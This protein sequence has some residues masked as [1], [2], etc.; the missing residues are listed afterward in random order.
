MMFL[1]IV[2]L[3]CSNFY[4]QREKDIFKISGLI[5]LVGVINA[6][7]S[8][9]L[10]ILSDSRLGI[11]NFQDIYS[12]RYYLVFAG[13]VLSITI[14]YLRYFKVTNYEEIQQKFYSMEEIRRTVYYVGASIYIITS[15][16]LVVASALNAHYKWWSL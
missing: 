6:N 15:L 10:F 7:F 1:D 13:L 2:Y 5:L 14:F 16:I 8:T 3:V 9:A 4:K 12:I 11:I